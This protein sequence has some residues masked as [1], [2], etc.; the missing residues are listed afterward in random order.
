MDFDTLFKTLADKNLADINDR[1][2]FESLIEKLRATD[3]LKAN[4][5][6]MAYDTGIYSKI[7]SNTK[8]DTEFKNKMSTVLINKHGVSEGNAKWA[9]DI[10][11]DVFGKKKEKKRIIIDTEKLN[12]GEKLPKD[13]V[14]R[15]FIAER[16]LNIEEISINTVFDKGFGDTNYIKV[17][18][19]VTYRKLDS[20]I[21][22]YVMVY[23]DKD[24][25]IGNSFEMSISPKKR[26]GFKTI[27]VNVYFP[28]GEKISRVVVRPGLDPVFL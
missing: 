1:N 8:L 15:E 24:V 23:N 16:S 4:V 10:C 3:R 17:V 19:E 6:M 12:D 20:Y 5:L 25:L 18:G 2:T 28:K 26:G 9:A 21:L 7:N 14:Q 27:S 22:I 13:I 11:C